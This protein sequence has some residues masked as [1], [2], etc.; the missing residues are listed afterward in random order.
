MRSPDRN[1]YDRQRG[2]SGFSSAPRGPSRGSHTGKGMGKARFFDTN[3]ESLE[4]PG[5]DGRQYLPD[6]SPGTNGENDSEHKD[7]DDE[8]ALSTPKANDMPPPSRPRSGDG[9]PLQ[10]A[11]PFKSIVGGTSTARPS[12][13]EQKSAG[14]RPFTL[15]LKSNKATPKP[16]LVPKALDTGRNASATGSNYEPLGRD[17]TRHAESKRDEVKRDEPEAHRL[18]ITA[19]NSR[20]QP[21]PKQPAP[22]API[23][24]PTVNLKE[25]PIYHRV[26]MV[27][28]GTYGYVS[29]NAFCLFD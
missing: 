15:S 24:K 7:F 28:E 8:G 23:P 12:V 2:G 16:N 26:S 11:R 13:D 4:Q 10:R 14:F 1:G 17:R 9:D 27:G 21:S 5:R 3:E 29:E 19:T 18:P 20:E 6:A 22:P 25:A